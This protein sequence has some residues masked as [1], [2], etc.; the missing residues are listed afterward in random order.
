MNPSDCPPRSWPGISYGI[1]EKTNYTL[2][3]A[4]VYLNISTRTVERLL[5]PVAGRGAAH[6]FPS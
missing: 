6:E 5:P 3:E 2:K 4:A 1:P